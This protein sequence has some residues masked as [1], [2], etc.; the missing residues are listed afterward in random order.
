INERIARSCSAIMFWTMSRN[1]KD[2]TEFQ[3]DIDAYITEMEAEDLQKKQRKA[4]QNAVEATKNTESADYKEEENE[5]EYVELLDYRN[6]SF[7]NMALASWKEQKD[8]ADQT[9]RTAIQSEIDSLCEQIY[10]KM[11][12]INDTEVRLNCIKMGLLQFQ[13]YCEGDHN[14]IVTEEA[15]DILEEVSKCISENIR[16]HLPS[17]HISV[18]VYNTLYSAK[19]WE[20]LLACCK[21]WLLFLSEHIDDPN[22]R[23]SYVTHIKFIQEIGIMLSEPMTL[24]ERYEYIEGCIKSCRGKQS[25]LDRGLKQVLINF[26]NQELQS[27]SNQAQIALEIYDKEYCL[28]SDSVTGMVRNLGKKQ[29]VDVVVELRIDDV[30]VHRCTLAKLEH[31]SMVPFSLP[32]HCDD[33]VESIDCQ[34]YIQYVTTEGRTENFIRNCKLQ[35]KSTEDADYDH[36]FFDTGSPAENENYVE[37]ELLQKKLKTLYS[38]RKTQL[39]LPSLVV[40]GMRR[41]G[42]SSLIRWLKKHVEENFGESVITTLL[43]LERVP[44]NIASLT[45]RV[46]YCLVEK[47]LES[48]SKHFAGEEWDAFCDSWSRPITPGDNFD[49]ILSFYTELK[50]SFLGDKHLFLI[51]D[52]IEGLYMNNRKNIAGRSMPE[53]EVLDESMNLSGPVGSDEPVDVTGQTNFW[54]A[55]SS[56]TQDSSYGITLVL[57]GADPFTNTVMAGD[58]LTQFFQRTEKLSIGR[59]TSSEIRVAMQKLEDDSD[60]VYHRDTIDYLWTLTAGLPW[61]SKRIINT[62]IEK[63]LIKENRITIY[64]YDVLFGA[65]E[66][67]SSVLD[68]SDN[69]MGM[70]ATGSDEKIFLKLLAEETISASTWVSKSVL[71]EKFKE[72]VVD[73]DASARFNKVLKIL[74]EGRQMIL[75]REIESDEEY[76]FGSEFNRLFARNQ[77]AIPQF[78]S[79]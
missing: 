79:K 65:N 47:T 57:C 28:E 21:P 25:T 77:K 70:S 66:I 72:T 17:N 48:I 34:V 2:I 71:W 59:M 20:S 29:A 73:E 78:I 36:A 67:F 23:Q 10:D 14:D 15:L 11:D 3:A 16:Y 8:S 45:E 54:D 6:L 40:Y 1:P 9:E 52:E 69:S 26:L 39:K 49:W 13:Q 56:V 76:R 35:A 5:N 41:M 75:K 42:K 44:K 74:I 22:K 19:N 68:V 64:P 38:A 46:Q 33:D 43:D 37:R 51:V 27:L 30:C 63:L 32:F 53:P 12:E 4:S 50:N 55:L 61:H 62:A 7:I 31:E 24:R 58:N 18:A 60:I